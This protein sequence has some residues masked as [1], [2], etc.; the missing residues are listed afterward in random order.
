MELENETAIR[1]FTPTFIQCFCPF[2]TGGL[3]KMLGFTG[4]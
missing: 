3:A 4:I 2:R 1:I